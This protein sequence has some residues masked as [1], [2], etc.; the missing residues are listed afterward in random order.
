MPELTIGELYEVETPHTFR[1]RFRGLKTEIDPHTKRAVRMVEFVTDDSPEHYQG[2][3]VR[4][5]N[6]DRCDIESVAAYE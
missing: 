1:G 4:V 3:G 5:V 6:L 2:G